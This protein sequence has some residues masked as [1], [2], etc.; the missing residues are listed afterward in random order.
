MGAYC[1]TKPTPDSRVQDGQPMMG[2]NMRRSDVEGGP[3]KSGFSEINT[4]ELVQTAAAAVK[5]TIGWLRAAHE[6]SR[7]A[8]FGAAGLVCFS[9]FLAFGNT[10][11]K[12]DIIGALTQI[13]FIMFGLTCIL[14]EVPAA[15]QHPYI[16]EFKIFIDTWLRALSRYT[17]RGF[18][19]FTHALLI[20]SGGAPHGAHARR[21]RMVF[22]SRH[23]DGRPGSLSQVDAQKNYS[24]FGELTGYA[25]AGAGLLSFGIG[26]VTTQDVLELKQK[27]RG[28]PDP[29][30]R[31]AA[32]EDVFRQVDKDGD[33]FLSVDE[34]K[35]LVRERH[36]HMTEEQLKYFFSNLDTNH[37]RRVSLAEFANC[38]GMPPSRHPPRRS[39]LTCAN[40]AMSQ[41]TTPRVSAWQRRTKGL[42]APPNPTVPSNCRR[43]RRPGTRT[44]RRT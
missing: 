42:R 22:P 17:G 1:S 14:L 26:W 33:G 36:P 41:G 21:V 16:I 25:L 44:W 40:P 6:V 2:W 24:K 34:V 27:V 12:S 29:A 32:A 43:E 15:G 9:S 28:E 30:G 19:Y 11:S 13:Y 7:L 20:V 10:M 38:A 3:T 5:S 39:G 8:I 31:V 18:V 35:T 37:D 4:E 23:L